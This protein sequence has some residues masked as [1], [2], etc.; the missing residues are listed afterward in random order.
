MIQ[1]TEPNTRPRFPLL[2]TQSLFTY[3][4]H[5]SS[6]LALSAL[7]YLPFFF[8]DLILGFQ[9]HQ[10]AMIIHGLLL[11][12]VF[13]LALPTL[14]MSGQFFPLATMR[15]LQRFFVSAVLLILL[16]FT[17]IRFGIQ[18]LAESGG[19]FSILLAA[20]GFVYLMF[21]GQFLILRNRQKLV[22]VLENV[23]ESFLLARKHF[24]GLML[25]YVGITMILSIP[26]N[27][28]RFGYVL[29]TDQELSHS[30]S[31][32][33]SRAQSE[34][35][36]TPRITV[37]PV[38]KGS[39]NQPQPIPTSPKRPERDPLMENETGKL[40]DQAMSQ[41]DAALVSTA[42]HLGLRP[43]KSLFLSFLFLTL[44]TPVRKEEVFSFLGIGQSMP[45]DTEESEE[46]KMT[47]AEE[48]A[49]AEPE[50]DDSVAPEAP[51]GDNGPDQDKPEANESNP[52]GNDE[53]PFSKKED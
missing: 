29:M 48:G 22:D 9:M 32:E 34:R 36:Q 2:A 1:G 13:F 5:F 19:S 14:Y 10:E 24:L 43:I 18:P 27:S 21:S 15:L 41:P 40:I 28:L 26:A 38:K 53:D 6:L 23:K 46:G 33:M 49:P 37:E 12:I 20:I 11:D 44:I 7:S 4:K 45:E 16:Q 31:E 39:P 52:V 51:S 50:L 8:L 35:P 30:L 47:Q 17:L 25:Y 42:L 3:K